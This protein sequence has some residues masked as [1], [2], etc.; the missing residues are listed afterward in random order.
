MDTEEHH[1]MCFMSSDLD[2]GDN[3]N[4]DPMLTDFHL[5]NALNLDVVRYLVLR[6]SPGYQLYVPRFQFQ[7]WREL[8]ELLPASFERVVGFLSITCQILLSEE[9]RTHTLS[10][11]LWKKLTRITT[12]GLIMKGIE[13]PITQYAS[14]VDQLNIRVPEV[15][16]TCFN[17]ILATISTLS[18]AIRG[19]KRAPY[20]EVT[21]SHNYA[22]ADLVPGS[23][24]KLIVGRNLSA[25]VDT[26]DKKVYIGN[27]DSVLLFMDTL[28]QRICAIAGN[29]IG[30]SYHVGGAYGDDVFNSIVR[31][32]DS[33]LALNGN[34]GFEVIAMFES[35][36]V[37]VILQKS[38]DHLGQESVFFQ[39][40][41]D[42]ATELCKEL[43]HPTQTM[44]L[45]GQWVQTLYQIEVDVLSNLFCIYRIWGHP[46]VD[47][48]AGME[49]V[50]MKAMVDKITVRQSEG[51]TLC[52]FRHMFLQSYLGKHRRYPPM[53]VEGSGY[54]SDCLNRGLPVDHK[55]HGYV[56]TDY[57]EV[58]IHQIWQV[59]ETYDVCH[60]L[61]DKAV[62]PTRR[63]LYESIS[64][65]S[66]T[67]NGTMRR[68][69]IRWMEGDSIRCRE[70][71]E[72]ID[73]DGLEQDDMI[74]GMYE[75][76]RE[77]KV[78]AR[79]FSLMSEKMRMY[80]VLTEELIANHILPYFPEITMKDPLNVQTRKI[81]KVGGMGQYELNPNIN[82][83]F[84]KWNLNMRPEFTNGL[85]EQMDRMFGFSNLILRT[86][87]IFRESY[88]YSCSGK[89]LPF[90]KHDMLM[91]DPPM[92]YIGHLGGFEGLRQKGWT[93]A[94]VCLLSYT[95]WQ[96]KLDM[97]LLGQGDNQVI[98]LYMPT[99]KWG[100]LLYTEEAKKRESI[101]LTNLYLDKMRLNFN[102]AGLPIKVRETW[103]SS[104]LFMYG[105]NMYLD[106]RGLPQW[107]KKLL[108][109]YALSNEGTLTISGVIGTI[110]T[111]MSAA[112]SVS[113]SPDVMY[114]LFLFMGEWSLEY[115]LQ[116]HPFTR[117][118]VRAGDRM[119]FQIP[120]SKKMI[121]TT[122]IFLHR[123]MTSILMVPTAVGGSVTI[124]LTG[125]IMRGFPDHASEGYAWLNM[126]RGVPSEFQSIFENWYTFKKNPSIQYDMLVQSP[127]SL[128]HHKPPTPGVQSR[129][130]VRGWLMSGRFSKNRFLANMGMIQKTF[131]RK[132]ICK[133]LISS[134]MNPLITYEVFNSFPQS[135]YD[136]VL[137]RLEGTRSVRKLAMR[138]SY[139]IPIVC[140][141][142]EVEFTHIAYLAWRGEIAGD[143]FS[144]CA[145]LQAR[146]ARD[147]GWEVELHGITT[148]HPL[149]YLF[150]TVCHGFNP[151]CV[152]G[153][154]IL[155][156][157]DPDGKYPPYL[158]SKVK[159]KV[160]SMQDEGARGEPL[161]CAN[162]RLA[163]YMKWLD[164]GENIVNVVK[165]CTE[166]LCDT[167]IFDNFYDLSPGCEGYTGCSE[168]RFNPSAA[169]DGCFI[170]YQA[171]LG[172]KVYMSGDY[173]PTYGKGKANYT[174]H[175]QAMFCLLQ[176]IAARRSCS[177]STH[178][179]LSCQTCI[180]P[181]DDS[182]ADIQS[183]HPSIDR[184]FSSE[185]ATLLR[186]TLGFLKDRPEVSIHPR[187]YLTV[188]NDIP[189]SEES[190]S[191]TQC[192]YGFS[193]MLAV[194]CALSILSKGREN[195]G[196]GLEDLQSFPRVYA[197]KL[198]VGTI[199]ESTY[200]ILLA[201]FVLRSGGGLGAINMLKAKKA[202]IRHLDR[203]PIDK[204][205]ELASLCL[206]RQS[207]LGL[208]RESIPTGQFP[209]D[210]SAFL[211]GTKTCLTELVNE[212]SGFIC[213]FPKRMVIGRL[214]I[215]EK[216]YRIILGMVGMAQLS[217]MECG[218]II[219]SEDSLTEFECRA[220]HMTGL[221]GRVVLTSCSLD[222][223]SKLL[224]VK[225]MICIE[226]STQEPLLLSCHVRQ[227]GSLFRN[228]GQSRSEVRERRRINAPTASL[229]KW[230]AV[231]SSLRD[232]P[233]VVIVLG[234]GTGGT[235]LVLSQRFQSA[236][237]F[238]LAKFEKHKVI[239]QD[240]DSLHPFLSRGARNI[241]YDLLD[242]LPDDINSSRWTLE[243][244]LALH[245]MSGNILIVSDIEGMDSMT[246][247]DRI[248]E[249]IVGLG[250][251][252]VIK[253][254][255]GDVLD[256][257]LSTL[258]FQRV[259]TT[260]HANGDL[261]ELF[262]LSS[263]L[264]VSSRT[265][266]D[267]VDD[268]KEQSMVEKRFPRA[269][270][271]S[272]AL[273]RGR[274]ASLGTSIGRRLLLGDPATLIAAFLGHV[275]SRYRF[276][277]DRIR[278]YDPRNLTD[279]ILI[280]LIRAFKIILASFSS[281]RIYTCEWYNRL[282]LARAGMGERDGHLF[283]QRINIALHPTTHIDSLSED[284]HASRT[285]RGFRCRIYIIDSFAQVATLASERSTRS[286]HA[287]DYDLIDGTETVETASDLSFQS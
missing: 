44:C 29:Q 28:G 97:T 145:T 199:V 209:E 16:I 245:K 168:H 164:L 228:I 242:V 261:G 179:H 277:Q 59:P 1:D 217:C 160:V 187:E 78:K 13:I 133:E 263:G 232:S 100:N 268:A 200:N 19:G 146:T 88:I 221:L 30:R 90:I 12:Q 208:V 264:S 171:Q 119:E 281:E 94:T 102:D 105:K 162:A 65:G 45:I 123:L 275:N 26:R 272:W 215:V 204:F 167:N 112:A 226:N 273:A 129:E 207:K 80:V 60:I 27:Y 104:R 269:T 274:L 213:N 206:G 265:K 107:T 127:W 96:T 34:K 148:P 71:L 109:S 130:M 258:R 186:D 11:Q 128:N 149:E 9:G 201:M 210:P 108:R 251:E 48:R 58:Q 55:S 153:D 235:S 116:Y 49:K 152:G 79:M 287:D 250:V 195:D 2:T 169:S 183:A 220:G 161:I 278:S 22:M 69:I 252:Y 276:P 136:S 138:E 205:K 279:G 267:G 248:T 52:Q 238:P 282:T 63:E 212:S 99:R 222:R 283:R 280:R 191:R 101:E 150:D 284:E 181:C 158:G 135:Y 126:L 35:L 230:T 203:T 46:E 246:I 81:W 166:T 95:A 76:E 156:R 231:L 7:A 144:N 286:R 233:D 57:L 256:C 139:T 75:K 41:I 87:D 190:I 155:V 262:L 106:G 185:T 68:G 176:Y 73:N 255:A 214:S 43:D 117:K 170:N 240:S 172:S 188:G 241:K 53:T 202:L 143:L 64:S 216:E 194:K 224:T 211:R 24:L 37:A 42:E 74:I 239:P 141:L 89:Y 132:E 219:T 247:Y 260:Q 18:E 6:Q 196:L 249:C 15:I 8:K 180:V 134:P 140:K 254:Y 36:V 113:D 257:H 124:P 270:S 157:T 39:N 182:I 85:F 253:I 84:E 197:Y 122:P 234:D 244:S 114:V 192:Y 50:Y 159:T 198:F 20:S 40:C 227:L 137:R 285:I 103:I 225:K 67:V 83:D 10:P 5:G 151:D 131:D 125:F 193:Y 120:G 47:I 62:S 38:P 91:L 25:I 17:I 66:G 175:F 223:M 218:G 3:C 98:K 163:R 174:I 259:V 237:I 229:Y 92:A 77:I 173:M 56:L 147:V 115:L 21:I 4:D 236:T 32:G 266:P 178:H 72:S 110:A 33:I 31:M 118:S 70:F 51:L 184:A 165:T 111:N 121:K 23:D 243:M 271:L 14:A 93:V 82:I 189:F 142:M 154:Y 86:H 61:N 54:V 177:T